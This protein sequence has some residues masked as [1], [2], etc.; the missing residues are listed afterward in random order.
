MRCRADGSRWGLAAAARRRNRSCSALKQSPTERPHAHCEKS[1]RTIL[2][3]W[4]GSLPVK[5][6]R[7]L[8]VPA[9]DLPSR[10][11][12]AADSV[13][14]AHIAGLLNFNI[15]FSHLRTLEQYREMIAAYLT[16]GGKKVIA[17]NRPVLVGPDDQAAMQIAEPALRTLWRRFRRMQDR[18]RYSRAR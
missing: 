4:D 8:P 18:R 1:L 11:W 15:L 3:A 5:G 12:L 16:A 14:A 9:A 13:A 7:L 17:A 2:A 6:S 10:C